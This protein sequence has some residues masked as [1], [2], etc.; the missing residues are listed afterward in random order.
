MANYKLK[1]ID[2]D[3]LKKLDL[4]NDEDEGNDAEG[5]IPFQWYIV[6]VISGNE[7]KVVQDMRDKIAGFGMS[8]K[9]AA[10]KII[11]EKIKEEKYY[12]P[13]DAP[14]SM[15]NKENV[16]WETVTVNG[17]TKYRVTKIKEGNKFNGYIFVKA[18]MTKQIWFLIRNTQLVT[19]I[20]GSSGKNVKPIPVSEDEIL[21][22]IDENNKKRETISFEDQSN[23]Q[24]DVIEVIQEQEVYTNFNIGQEV[25]IVANN[26]FGEIARIVSIDTD[27]KI[28]T[29]EFDFFGRINT[30]TLSLNE[31]EPLLEEENE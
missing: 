30:T 17:Q 13:E 31:L 20:V 19:G 21:K 14:R 23:K 10:I 27:K 7:Q 28:A 22:L 16:R 24:N 11:K 12:S 25:K 15:K 3:W 29:I 1:D 6:T 2:R 8:D 4:I 18:K 9:I 26:F 5:N